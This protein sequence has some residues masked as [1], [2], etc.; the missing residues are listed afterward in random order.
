MHSRRSNVDYRIQSLHITGIKTHIIHICCRDDL[1]FNC[2]IDR[3]AH[4]V[5]HLK[6]HF[7]QY[8]VRVPCISRLDQI[9][10]RGKRPFAGIAAIIDSIVRVHLTICPISSCGCFHKIIPD[11]GNCFSSF[12]TAFLINSSAFQLVAL[13]IDTQSQNLQARIPRKV[14]V[15]INGFAGHSSL[16]VVNPDTQLVIRVDRHDDKAH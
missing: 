1:S 5:F 10:K 13:I 7:S 11:V 15:E 4:A 9:R 3:N 16:V 14:H 2:S 8:T 6:R 12:F